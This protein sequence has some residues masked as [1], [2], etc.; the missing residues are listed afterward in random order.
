M[1]IDV[2]RDY[3]GLSQALTE[4]LE[5]DFAFA[6][7]R[8]AF[9]RSQGE[10]RMHVLNGLPPRTLSPGYYK[11]ASYILWL[12]ERIKAGARFER[13]AAWELDGLVALE[14]A[15]AKFEYD[16]PT[17]ACGAHQQSRF[18]SKCHACGLDFV[19]KGVA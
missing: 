7:V 15:R 1:T 18:E 11:L 12:E 9:E 2:A 10:D 19:K 17:C 3:E 6:C 5:E 14:R 16:H 13:M 4:V 8:R